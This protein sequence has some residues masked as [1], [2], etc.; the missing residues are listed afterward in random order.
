[1][2]TAN[3]EIMYEALLSHAKYHLR[4]ERNAHSMS[5]TVLVHE[6][7]LA[8]ARSRL[9]R[10]VDD[11]HYTRLI[12]RVMR[13]LLI[14]R[15]RRR[16]S[17]INGG[18]MQRLETWDEIPAASN[19][20]EEELLVAEAMEK[21]AARCPSL[22]ELVQLRY[23][24]GFTEGEVARILH[25]SSRSVRRQWGVARLRLLEILSDGRT[26]RNGVH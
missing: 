1:M 23:F 8:L 14:D 9:L 10:V 13:N 5:A 18:S 11:D 20:I 6:A 24:C 21:L 22:A 2:T 15:A 12:S 7:W 19:I 4:R 25:V 3:I 16:K 17:E 26:D